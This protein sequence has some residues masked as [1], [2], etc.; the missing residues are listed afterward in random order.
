MGEKKRETGFATAAD[1]P[2]PR[3]L[4]KEWSRQS[5]G[6]CLSLPNL[7]LMDKTVSLLQKKGSINCP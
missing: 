2:D 3:Q 7:L 4:S 1:C 6:A 5:P